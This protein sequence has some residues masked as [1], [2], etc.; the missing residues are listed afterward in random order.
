[1]PAARSSD[2]RD[3]LV[4]GRVLMREREVLTLDEADVL[5]R[6]RLHAD[7]LAQATQ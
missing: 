2:V 4:D 6:A 3:T 1:M 5:S 7:R